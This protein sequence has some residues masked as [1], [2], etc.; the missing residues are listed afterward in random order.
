MKK[1]ALLMVL[2][3]TL[4]ISSVFATEDVL[5]IA[6][7]PTDALSG[8]VVSGEELSGE[9]VT[10]TEETPVSGDVAEEAVSGEDETPV[11]DNETNDA[12]ENHVHDDAETEEE[13]T[14]DSNKNSVIGAIIAIVIVV[15]VVAIAAI[16]RKD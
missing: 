11:L 4:S 12:D 8:E 14:N 7:A 2:V 13:V 6:P 15:A 9:V 10:N 5:L 3:L 1:V 16:L